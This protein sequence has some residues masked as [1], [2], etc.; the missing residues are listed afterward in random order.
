MFRERLLDALDAF[1]SFGSS[2]QAPVQ[3][4]TP[5]THGWTLA[6]RVPSISRTAALCLGE[7]ARRVAVLQLAASEIA[8]LSWEDIDGEV[9]RLRAENA[10][11]RE[12]RSLAIEGELADVFQRRKAA[13]QVTMPDGSVV[14]CPLVFHRDGQPVKDFRKAWY[15]ACVMAGL[16]NLVCRKCGSDTDANQKCLNCGAEWKRDELRYEGRIFHDFRRTAVRDMVR[17]GVRESA[18]MSISGHKTRSMFD[19]YNIHDERDQREALRA[20]QAYREQQAAA[21][22]DK[23][24]PMRQQWTGVH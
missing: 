19:R 15:S 24:T 16:G 11:I 6:R 23:I 1:L 12:A 18:A 14:L 3:P 7:I 22:K 17:A 21:L 2:A 9:I 10:K 5:V 8:S 20:T 4:T 13:R